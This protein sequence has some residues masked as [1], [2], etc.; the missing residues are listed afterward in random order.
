MNSIA[1]ELLAERVFDPA[2][3]AAHYTLPK[4]RKR[5]S[6]YRDNSLDLARII[7]TDEVA[8]LYLCCGLLRVGI[9]V[10]VSTSRRRM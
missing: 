10:P 5:P 7:V 3:R 9:E 1:A 4:R 2:L 6:E 8:S